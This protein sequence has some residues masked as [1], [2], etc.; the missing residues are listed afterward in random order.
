MYGVPTEPRKIDEA[1]WLR[2]RGLSVRLIAQA[3]G[4][5][6]STVGEL[7][8][9][10]GETLLELRCE[11]CGGDFVAFRSDKRFCDPDCYQRWYRGRPPK[12]RKD[13]KV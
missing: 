9:G 12:R 8:K 10:E 13:S 1:R 6:R 2:A 3:T 7:L 5:P 11:G 4:L